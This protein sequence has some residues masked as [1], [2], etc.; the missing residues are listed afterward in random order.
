MHALRSTLLA[1]GACAAML[2]AWAAVSPNLISNPGNESPLVA[3]NIPGWQEVL[4]TTWTQ[5]TA[6]PD[7][8]EGSFYFFAG[9]NALAT[10]RQSV[11]VGAFSSEIDAGLLQFDFSGR[12]RSFEQSSPDSATISLRFLDG[13]S[14]VLQ[15]FS[16]G[17][18]INTGAWQLV[19][20]S[21]LAPVNTRSVEISLTATRNAGSN[22][23][24]YFDDLHL[25]AVSAVPEPSS[26]AMLLAGLA[27]T[28]GV[29]R[30]R[31][32]SAI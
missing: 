6:S 21:V 27:A 25:S 7:A 12:V 5:R 11:D 28:L 4:G 29:V 10:L 23:D 18:I 2:P 17:A 9:A 3:D 8:F 30:R 15:T 20:T 32:A 1:F 13:A 19:S 14:G 24:G 22:N 16:S 31:R 26:H